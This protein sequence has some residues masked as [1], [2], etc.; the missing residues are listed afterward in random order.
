MYIG[1]MS[2][3]DLELAMFCHRV[4]FQLAEAKY[5]S[6][7]TTHVHHA[8]TLL[9]A[10]R[11]IS[12]LPTLL[13]APAIHLT[14]LSATVEQVVSGYF[15]EA[16]YTTFMSFALQLLTNLPPESK[17]ILQKCTPVE[18]MEIGHNS[19]FQGCVL[20]GLR[21]RSTDVID[22]CWFPTPTA[23]ASLH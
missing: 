12:G 6:L 9:R 21:H 1:G 17:Q 7:Q 10:H 8:G 15:G 2:C 22:L 13:H 18:M 23:I 3:E 20:P 14:I 19:S 4:Y 11:P 16:G 5:H